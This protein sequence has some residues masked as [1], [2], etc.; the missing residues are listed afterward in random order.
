M[1]QVLPIPAAVQI[2][3]GTMKR[4]SRKIPKFTKI[5]LADDFNVSGLRPYVNRVL[6]V[7]GHPE[8][9][10]TDESMVSD[11]LDFSDL[12]EKRMRSVLRFS[13]KLGIDILMEDL[14]WEAAQ[15]LKDFNA[16]VD[17]LADRHLG[18]V[19]AGGSRPPVGSRSERKGKR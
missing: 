10:V 13:K 7:M 15:R 11:F 17:Q 8:A 14:I 5:E 1:A 2:G 9:L 12:K 6:A 4:K 19:E 3:N 18:K 16:H